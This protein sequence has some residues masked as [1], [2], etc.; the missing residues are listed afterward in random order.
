MS[1]LFLKCTYVMY[2]KIEQVRNLVIKHL[3]TG[4]DEEE[5]KVLDEWMN[6]SPINRD[7]IREFM[8]EETLRSGIINLYQSRERVWKRVEEKL[9][10]VRVINTRKRIWI[11]TAVAATLMLLISAGA[12]FNYMHKQ[13]SLKT[14]NT[15]YVNDVDPGGN[16][17]VLTL[18]DGS[19]IILDKAQNGNLAQQGNTNII[20]LSNGKLL[21]RPS[22]NDTITHSRINTLATPRGGQ[23]QITLPD[24]TEIW[25]NSASSIKYPTAFT[26]KERRVEITGEVYFEVAKNAAMP[27]IVKIN[28]STEVKALGTSFNINAY[29]DESAIRTTLLEGKVMVSSALSLSKSRVSTIILSPGQQAS[30]DA[31]GIINVSIADTDQ[32][33]AWKN[34]K[35]IFHNVDIATILREISRWYDLEIEIKG[36]LPDRTFFLEGRRTAKLSEIL[37][38]LEVNHIPFHLD[39]ENRKLTV[40]P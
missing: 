33:L 25:L 14:D 20:K 38:G 17:A 3:E 19:V 1:V 31:Q 36:K 10:V 4:L 6:E 13:Y 28:N 2:K 22:S 37:R 16:N 32:A 18:A 23:Y 34:G 12:V 7:A 21:Y 39:A 5:K 11:W 9:P 27:F 15:A 29:N 35:F 40:N 24:G 26:G 30:L 8:E